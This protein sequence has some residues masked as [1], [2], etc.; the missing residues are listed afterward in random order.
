M[1]ITTTCDARQE[2]EQSSLT[3]ELGTV[4]EQAFD[5]FSINLETKQSRL[6]GLEE[7]LT[8]SSLGREALGEL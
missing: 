3:Q 6:L 5:V 1:E 8:G 7:V 2:S 4:N